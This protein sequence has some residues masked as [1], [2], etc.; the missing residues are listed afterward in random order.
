MDSCL[1]HLGSRDGAI[2]VNPATHDLSAVQITDVLTRDILEM[3]NLN[4]MTMIRN[5]KI[6]FMQRLGPWFLLA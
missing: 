5:G 1:G 3:A 2:D 4:F 6:L